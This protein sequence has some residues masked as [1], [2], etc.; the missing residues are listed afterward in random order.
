MSKN[1]LATFQSVVNGDMSSDVISEPTDIRW[2]DNMV[3]YIDF[4]GT[5][6]GTF[7]AETSPDKVSWYALNLVPTPVAS[8]VAGNHRIDMNQLPDP[9]IR[10][11]YT[12]TSGSGTLNVKIAGK[13][14]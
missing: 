2:L 11:K 7:S 10:T 1:V 6:T 8:G 3:M 5:P 9:Y 14:I 13:L 12:R 4:I